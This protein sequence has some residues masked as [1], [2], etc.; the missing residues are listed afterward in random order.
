MLELDPPVPFTLPPHGFSVLLVGC[1]GTGSFLAQS[2]AR[3]AYHVK[4]AGETEIA[5][6]FMD[7]DVVEPK[8]VGRQLF[9]P[10]EVGMNKA[11]ALAARFNAALGLK[12]TAFP[13]MATGEI[14]GMVGTGSGSTGIL[15]GA[16]DSAA[17]RRALDAALLSNQWRLWLDCGNHEH[18]GQV[19]VGT[20]IKQDQ[21]QGA[22]AL[23][24]MCSALPAA[25]LLYPE[26]LQDQA[27]PVIDC[28]AAMAQNIQSLTVNQM[29][30]SIATEY[31][32]K[33]IVRRR[34][35]TFQTVVDLETLSA[36][37]TPITPKR[38]AKETGVPIEDLMTV[39][40]KGWAA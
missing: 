9:A 36:T 13:R 19:V 6:G 14:L 11:E 30:A 27:A 23:G 15:V 8:N 16:V 29:M 40:K 25:S 37:S 28:A 12:I 26:L 17:G 33:L 10:A 32:Y 1:G 39:K 18:A 22:F 21:L 4:Q 31:L 20:A 7:G 38:I 34:I 5:M 3:L 24:G 2:L 35:T